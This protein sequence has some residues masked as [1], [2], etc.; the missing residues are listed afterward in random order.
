MKLTKKDKQFLMANGCEEKDFR[1]IEQ[2]ASKTIYEH[3]PKTGA[4]WKITMQRAADDYT[5][6]G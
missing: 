4:G 6:E 3:Y 2:A 1:Q 5:M